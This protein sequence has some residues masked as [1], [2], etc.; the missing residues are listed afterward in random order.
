MK[1]EKI[2]VNITL[3]KDLLEKVKGKLTLFGGKLSTLC[4]AYL[5]EFVR[6][7]DKPFVNQQKAF[8]HRLKE[9]EEKIKK[10]GKTK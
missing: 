6:T 9:L 8:E 2:R 3:D 1:K 7:M 10:L 5:A 4:N